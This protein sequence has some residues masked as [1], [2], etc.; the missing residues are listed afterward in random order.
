MPS[1]YQGKDVVK[2]VKVLGPLQL[3]HEIVVK[4]L[5]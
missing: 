5:T 1:N 3:W 4:Q 2:V